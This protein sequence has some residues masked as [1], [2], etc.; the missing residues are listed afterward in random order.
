MLYEFGGLI[1]GGDYFRNFTVTCTAV[2]CESTA[3]MW[4]KKIRTNLQDSKYE[5][6]AY[7]HHMLVVHSAERH[8]YQRRA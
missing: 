3:E 1:F 6:K 5:M 7:H 8:H 2:P 4:F